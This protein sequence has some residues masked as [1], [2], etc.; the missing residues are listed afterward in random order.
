MT[1]PFSP[2]ELA[3]LEAHKHEERYQEIRWVYSVPI[4]AAT[5]STALRFSAK[6]LGRNGITLDDY[7]ILAATICLIGQCASGLGFG[8][9][10]ASHTPPF[11]MADSS[12]PAPWHGQTCH[13]RL[14]V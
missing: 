9:N 1:S 3:Y 2:A 8:T 13:R 4:V 14:P 6:R 5:I 11:A 10:R 7:L 12:R